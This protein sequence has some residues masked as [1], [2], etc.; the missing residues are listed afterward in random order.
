MFYEHFTHF[1]VLSYSYR[2]SLPLNIFRPKTFFSF[3]VHFLSSSICCNS[4]TLACFSFTALSSSA[5]RI[6]CI[7]SYNFEL[8]LNAT[9]Y[10]QH[11]SN[12]ELWLSELHEKTSAPVTCVVHL[13]IH[14]SFNTSTGH[15]V[16]L[17]AAPLPVLEVADMKQK[18]PWNG[19]LVFILNSAPSTSGRR[20][21]LDST[22][23][24]VMQHT[25]RV[26]K[27]ILFIFHNP[28]RYMK[29]SGFYRS[30]V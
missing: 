23:Y 28:L 11:E 25:T 6:S 12:W 29:Q 21:C 7:S 13:I 24:G 18:P 19:S 2:Y 5:T 8:E 22:A 14:I 4:F 10:Q 30:S 16:R 9:I 27:I 3:Q 1:Y 15:H 26:L 17:Q 20:T